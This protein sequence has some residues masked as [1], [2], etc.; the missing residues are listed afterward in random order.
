MKILP[1]EQNAALGTWPCHVLAA[2]ATAA[3]S[4]LLLSSC[5]GPDAHE[6][7]VHGSRLTRYAERILGVDPSFPTNPL[8]LVPVVTD[9]GDFTLTYQVPVRADVR[10]NGG[11]L[12][13]QDNCREARLSLFERQT[14][15]TYLVYWT[16]LCSELGLHTVR[17]ELATCEGD[18]LGPKRVENITNVLHFHPYPTL[19]GTRLYVRAFLQATSADYTI[20]P[21]NTNNARFKTIT[22]HTDNGVIDE[23]WDFWTAGATPYNGQEIVA[24]ICVTP[25]ARTSN[26][27]AVPTGPKVRVPIPF[28]K[29]GP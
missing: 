25:T 4:L 9:P 20:E 1:R 23:A 17:V 28:S 27:V 22:G 19:S 16:T 21:C 26:G 13:L 24:Q 6:V 15:G 29:E 2:T 18:F 14:N 3:T 10:S 12:R 7:D 5:S 11:H 8:V